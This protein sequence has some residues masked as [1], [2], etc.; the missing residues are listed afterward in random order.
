[1]S[2]GSAFSAPVNLGMTRPEELALKE[3]VD[4]DGDGDDDLL[5]VTEADG[6]YNL[7][8]RRAGPDGLGDSTTWSRIAAP[9]TDLSIRQ[10]GPDQPIEVLVTTS[11][12]E[13]PCVEHRLALS[14]YLLSAHAYEQAIQRVRRQVMEFSPE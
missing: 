12:E 6:G 7:D 9:V 11:C 2:T 8:T 13:P 14:G 5:T 10:L 3:M 4:F 1:M